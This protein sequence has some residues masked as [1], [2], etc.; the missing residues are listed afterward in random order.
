MEPTLEAQLREVVTELKDNISDW[1]DQKL[2]ELGA[3]IGASDEP[4]S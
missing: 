1:L 2:D 3:K 4:T